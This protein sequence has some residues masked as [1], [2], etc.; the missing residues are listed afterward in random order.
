MSRATAS[1]LLMLAFGVP[2]FASAAGPDEN[3]KLRIFF[4]R[5]WRRGLEEYPEGAT[6]LGVND[7]NDRLTDQSLAAIDARRSHTRA[8]LEEL[9][10]FDRARLSSDNQLNLDLY[11]RDLAEEI[12]GF[13][14]PTELAPIGPVGGIHRE[15]PSL[16]AQTPFRNVHDYEMYLG[17]LRAFPAQMDQILERMRLGVQRKWTPPAAILRKIPAQIEMLAS[18]PVE[19]TAFFAPFKKFPVSVGAAERAKLESDARAAI[20]TQVQPAFRRLHDYLAAVYIPHCRQDVG[21]WALPDGAAWYVHVVREHTTTAM[22]PE[23][24]HQ[25]G[26]EQ[27]VKIHGQMEAVIAKTGFRGTFAEFLAFLRTDPRFY[28]S[29][30]DELLRRYRDIC[31]RIDG[32]LPKLFAK[33]PRNPY[34]VDAIPASEAATTYPGYYQPGAPDGSRAGYFM[35]NTSKLGERPTYQMEVLATHESVPGHHLQISRAQEIEGLPDFR[36]NAYY[37]AFG[38]GWGLYC[39]TLGKDLGLYA[40]PYSEFAFLSFQMWRACRLVVDTGI[41]EFHW[42]RQRA[43]DYMTENTVLARADVEVEVD[44]Y[45]SWPGQAL[46]YMIGEMKIL[47]LRSRAA[48]ELKDRFDV[49]KFH[50]AVL[51]GGSL[52]L[53]ILQ[54]RIDSWIVSQTSNADR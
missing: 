14:F 41:H 5:E 4:D 3:A 36:R 22:T 19:E 13:R 8:A 12:D 18:E 15:F 31:K 48:S 21:A 43:I 53:D 20:A 11:R 38:E 23:S 44:R 42:E 54:S 16:A 28:L 32:E 40:D 51:D 7:W 30:A 35:V 17:R 46:A 6:L 49:R 25:L 24:I 37:D 39:E 47:E 52:P 29:S 33:L 10:S 1:M 9:K 2:A 50:E 26:L 45:I 34:G 27:V